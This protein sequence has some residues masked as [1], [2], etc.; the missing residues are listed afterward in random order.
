ML[1]TLCTDI[2]AACWGELATALADARVP[3]A[4]GDVTCLRRLAKLDPDLVATIVRWIR[5]A[6]PTSQEK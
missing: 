3:L 1:D 4:V 5:T 2:A 6:R